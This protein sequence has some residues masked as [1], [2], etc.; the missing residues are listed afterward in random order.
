MSVFRAGAGGLALLLAAALGCTAGIE[1]GPGDVVPEQAPW[2]GGGAMSSEQT[3]RGRSA[4]RVTVPANDARFLWQETPGGVGG[5]GAIALDLWTDA[6]QNLARVSVMARSGGPRDQDDAIAST[7]GFVAGWNHVVFP[8]RR[9]FSH[10]FSKFAWASSQAIAVRIETNGNGPAEVRMGDVRIVGE[11]PRGGGAGASPAAGAATAGTD[12]APVVDRLALADV[13]PS[14]ATVVLHTDAPSTA[15]LEYGPTTS[16]G[17]RVADPARGT[18]HELRAKLDANRV[19]H[20]R[21]RVRD[22]AARERTTSDFTFTTA[23]AQAPPAPVPFELGMFGVTT[24][25]DVADAARGPFNVFQSYQWASASHN[26]NDD[27]RRY[28]DVAQKFGKGVIVGFDHDRATAGDLEYVRGRV[29]ALAAHPAVHAWYLF[30]EPEVHKLDPQVLDAMARAIRAEDPKRP[31]V[32]GAS[33]LDSSYPY[34]GSFDLALLDRYPVPF[35]SPAAIVPALDDARRSGMGF[36]FTFQ[37]YAVDLDHRW[38]ASAAGPGRYPTR[39]EMRLM[40]FL[41]IA[42]G[43]RALWAF[44]YDYLHFTPGSEWKWVDLA[45]VGREIVDLSVLWASDAPART[46]ARPPMF[47][48]LDV[49]VRSAAGDDW[50]VIANTAPREVAAT[51][52]LTPPGARTVERVDAMAAIDR[53]PVAFANDKLT[54]RWRPYDVQVFRIRR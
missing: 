1:Q 53:A 2:Q 8:R 14:G 13:G 29:R 23:R 49:S 19:W 47:S 11:P 54:S 44:S 34:R 35:A 6:P 10:W 25:D 18:H 31:L 51:L 3:P 42:H 46:Q 21:V 50:L 15:T 52:T 4:W 40:A 28:L 43:A 37:A 48:G 24:A 26:E 41:A 16:Y 45:E 27:V 20:A 39:D 22:A 33:V 17:S 30:D 5:S 12:D 7:S 36:G 38:P 9:F 32:I